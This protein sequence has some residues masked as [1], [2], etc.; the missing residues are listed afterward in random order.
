MEEL[1][2]RNVPW[3]KKHHHGKKK[4]KLDGTW[5][6]K[7]G[8]SKVARAEYERQFIDGS[9]PV[10][11]MSDDK[12][13]AIADEQAYQAKLMVSAEAQ[14][15]QKA[16]AIELRKKKTAAVEKEKGHGFKNNE[17]GPFDLFG[18]HWERGE[19]KPVPEDIQKEKQFKHAVKLGCLVEV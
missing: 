14:A 12:K 17:T 10:V 18:I 6:N 8:S 15:K 7:R 16:E 11:E 13:K 2:S 3:N 5:A 1:D 9:E 4:K 19:V